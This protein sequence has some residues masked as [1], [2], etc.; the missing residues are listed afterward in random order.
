MRSAA[1]TLALAAAFAAPAAEN[2][3]L[4][5][6]DKIANDN[7]I[8]L[9]VA[10][11]YYWEYFFKFCT[12]ERRAEIV[13][14]NL[15]AQKKRIAIDGA[16]MKYRIRY[17]D[18]LLHLGR[19][20]EAIPQY[21]AVIGN[22][23]K[24]DSA[25]YANACYGKAECLYGLGRKAEAKEELTKLVETKI[26]TSRSGMF[27][28][29]NAARDCLFWLKG[30]TFDER[31]LPCSTG[32]KAYP[33]PQK[34]DYTEDFLPLT[35]LSVA[36]KGLE[37]TDARVKL[38]ETKMRRLGVRTAVGK[39]G[40]SGGLRLEI[41]L[42]PNAPVDKPEG[43]SIQVCDKGAKIV[44]RDRQGAL[45][46][47]VTFIQLVDAKKK[48]IRC[49]R[50]DDWPD[51]PKR[52]YLRG[53]S[54]HHVEFSLFAKIN[55]VCIQTRPYCFEDRF[56]PLEKMKA[57][58]EAKAFKD[59]G[60]DLYYGICW[61]TMY[62]MLP[63]SEER[64]FKKHLEICRFYASVGA[65]VYFPFDDGRFPLHE[66]DLK[67]GKTGADLDAKH[68]DR[69]FK[70]VRDEYPDFRMV[71]CPPFYWGPDSRANY[72]EPREPYLKSVGQ[73]LD[74]AVDVY[75]TGPRVKGYGKNKGQVKWYSDLIGRKPAIFQNA[76]GAHNQISC[77]VDC[78]GW[79]T[80]HYKGFTKDISMFHLN[81]NSDVDG[82][83]IWTCA[84]WLWNES[85]H[86][87]VRSIRGAVGGLVGEGAYDILD[88]KHEAIA[89]FDKY[90]WGQVNSN[91]EKESLPELESRLKIAKQAWSD[92]WEAAP[93][94]RHYLGGY[95]WCIGFAEKVVAAA[96]K[97]F[98]SRFKNE[99]SAVEKAA[100]D[101][102]AYH[103][104]K[105]E[106]LLTPLDLTGPDPHTYEERFAREIKT[107][108]GKETVGGRFECDPFPPSGPYEAVI[109]ATGA[110]D[111]VL[112]LNG[113]QVWTA[114]A[115][116]SEL[117][118]SQVKVA[119]PFADLKRFNDLTLTNAGG[120][121]FAVNYIVIR[122][123]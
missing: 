118:Y 2:A 116:F 100:V 98:K 3:A 117:E 93:N 107:G 19:F 23:K 67:A 54:I 76:T 66:R 70:A 62:P 122:R 42:K 27:D 58:A 25:V 72:P 30:P 38:L 47:I 105:G 83:M 60:I 86:R 24:V 20:K 89:Y 18:A 82:P 53:E 64:S 11:N 22:R 41:A 45:W 39:K 8:T 119:L 87:H 114:K 10:N 88:T 81:C 5:E 96:R 44:A 40:G 50:I 9:G 106:I 115:A 108:G 95:S 75:W 102:G 36:L 21:E 101:D 68:V 13:E 46:G 77:G 43:Y 110:G 15:A 109:C 91:I 29:V 79:D 65:G 73:N 121:P 123:K 6:L 56:S 103:K 37:P 49:C 28:A 99:L 16:N 14:K 113:K 61:A 26:D 85:N 120:K 97:H 7:S 59:F 31:G 63:L 12:D 92:V 112:S 35:S 111:P 32:A 55:S 78:T 34:A 90:K 69:V 80:W 57:A 104:D 94:S 51:C 4:K 52:G 48:A 74:P 84:D 71:F 33:E 17:A 1:L